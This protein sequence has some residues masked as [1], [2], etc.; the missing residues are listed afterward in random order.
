MSITGCGCRPSTSRELAPLEPAH[1]ARELDHRHLH[2]QA[3]AEVRHC[4]SR[5]YRTARDLALD[6]ALAEAARNHNRVG[7][8]ERVAAVPSPSSSSESM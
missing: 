8:P 7:R 2:A 4:F 6:A 5:A 3:D 1:V